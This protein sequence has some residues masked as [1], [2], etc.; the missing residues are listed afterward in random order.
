MEMRGKTEIQRK[1]VCQ[2]LCS[3]GGFSWRAMDSSHWGGCVVLEVC[4]KE[5]LGAFCSLMLSLHA[6][7]AQKAFTAT[8]NRSM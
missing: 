3:A 4:W 8:S 7:A 1:P 6:T 2:I 5:A